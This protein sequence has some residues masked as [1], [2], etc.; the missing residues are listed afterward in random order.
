MRRKQKTPGQFVRWLMARVGGDPTQV[1][2]PPPR[3]GVKITVQSLG[4]DAHLA[5][6]EKEKRPHNDTNLVYL[7]ARVSRPIAEAN[8]SSD[9]ALEVITG[10]PPRRIY[11]RAIPRAVADLRSL[12]RGDAITLIGTLEG[13]YVRAQEARLF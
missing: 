7:T 13:A 10:E 8:L 12:K 9:P 4:H 2:I 1:I 6:I 3:R 5:L 11:V